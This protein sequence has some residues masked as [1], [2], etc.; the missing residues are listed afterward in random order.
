MEVLKWAESHRR[1]EVVG[2]DFL[3]GTIRRYPMV[4]SLQPG[5][6]V[7]IFPWSKP[8]INLLH[9]PVD[10]WEYDVDNVFD[11]QVFR[12]ADGAEHDLTFDV[13]ATGVFAGWDD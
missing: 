7:N 8:V 13:P 5:E 2:K 3:G 9:E 11:H 6:S 1:R 4:T 10:V 12:T